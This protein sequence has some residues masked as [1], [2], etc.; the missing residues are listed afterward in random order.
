MGDSYKEVCWHDKMLKETSQLLTLQCLSDDMWEQSQDTTTNTE[1]SRDSA[2]IDLKT[3]NVTSTE[4]RGS[5]LVT[6]NTV[7]QRTEDVKIHVSSYYSRHTEN[8]EE[9]FDLLEKGSKRRSGDT[10]IENS[11]KKM[12]LG[13]KRDAEVACSTSAAKMNEGC[14]TIPFE[15][16]AQIAKSRAVIENKS[17]QCQVVPAVSSKVTTSDILQSRKLPE[18]RDKRN[19]CDDNDVM[20]VIESDKMI[21]K[22]RQAS[23]DSMLDS[24]LGDSCNSVDSTEEKYGMTE[25]KNR[26]LERHCWQPKIRE[27][28][29][30]RLPGISL[31][32]P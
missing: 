19:K 13:N 16:K 28:L 12:N 23:V 3:H 7:P 32:V 25:L 30:T 5:L 14:V 9:S 31:L 27:S 10:S 24:G 20:D 1:L 21:P 11:P 6:T 15:G 17:E 29:A 26:R 18:S 4:C 2:E 22:P 8:T